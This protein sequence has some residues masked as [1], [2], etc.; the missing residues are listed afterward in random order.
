MAY[1]YTDISELRSRMLAE[2]EQYVACRNDT[3]LRDSVEYTEEQFSNCLDNV[4]SLVETLT[5]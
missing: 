1:Q 3:T 5:A 2:I 4:I